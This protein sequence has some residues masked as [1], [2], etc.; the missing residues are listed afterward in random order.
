MRF[1]LCR[2]YPGRGLLLLCF[3]WRHLFWSGE[4]VSGK[5]QPSF[6][7]HS[8]KKITRFFLF[9]VVYIDMNIYSLLCY[10]WYCIV[11]YYILCGEG[12]G[13]IT[14]DVVAST[15]RVLKASS[16]PP[17]HSRSRLLQVVLPFPLL[18]SF[19]NLLPCSTLSSRPSAYIN[20]LS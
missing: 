12:G 18:S 3:E 15:L 17:S 6:A 2:V 20:I 1:E 13:F 14:S 8:L 11:M 4:P 7:T 10:T 16:V 5:C 19:C 9:L